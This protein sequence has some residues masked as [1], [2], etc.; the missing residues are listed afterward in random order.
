LI[1]WESVAQRLIFDSGGY[2]QVATVRTLY[3][4]TNTGPAVGGLLVDAAGDLFGTTTGGGA[5]GKGVLFELVNNGGGSY[6]F[7]TLVSFNGGNGAYP[8]GTLIADTAGDLFGTTY[9]GG[10]TNSD[11]TVF[12]ILKTSAGYASTPITLVNFDGSNGAG[13]IAGLTADVLATSSARRPSP[14]RAVVAL[15][16]RFSR[17]PPAMAR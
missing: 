6:T 8:E 5:G 2:A 10:T 11:E 17:T 1:G 7:S 16:L 15:C 12:E 3:T 9:G 14:G 4:F 13:P